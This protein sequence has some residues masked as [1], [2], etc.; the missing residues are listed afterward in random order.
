MPGVR[1]AVLAPVWSAIPPPGYG[2]VETVVA[3][4]TDGLVDAGHDVTLFATGDSRTK[5]TLAS[6]LPEPPDRPARRTAA[7]V[8][9][10]VECLLRAD[11]FDVVNSHLGPLAGGLSVAST[12]PLVHTVADPIDRARDLWGQLARLNPSL[13][14]ISVSRRQQELAPE[15][16]WLAVCHNGLPLENYRFRAERG[17]YLAFLGRMSPD[18]GCEIAIAVAHRTGLQLRIGAKL[19]EQH[20]RDYFA[21]FVEPHLGNGVEYIGEPTHVEKIDLLGGALAT[22]FPV[23]AEEAFGLVA[24]ESMA[25]GTP[26]IALR[27][28]A[29]PEV[30]AHGVT[31]VVAEDEDGLVAGV[32]SA[33]TFARAACRRHVEERFS[34]EPLVQRYELAYELAL[35]RSAIRAE[36][37]S[38]RRSARGRR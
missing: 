15:L 2:G 7:E 8:R 29:V 16:P 5:A 20:E 34:T 26:V 10:A 33:H 4:L 28:G 35:R 37:A 12:K 14:L 22:L 32:E 27:R 23:T 30:V 6:V 1:I 18:K 19:R 36:R 38:R 25:C 24:A 21:T 17:G 3:A 11:E 13:L 9:H 31:G